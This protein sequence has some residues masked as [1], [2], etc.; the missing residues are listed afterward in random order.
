MCQGEL[1]NLKKKMIWER[2]VEAIT[3]Q[4]KGVTLIWLL[5]LLGLN[6]RK[7][8]SNVQHEGFKVDTGENF[9]ALRDSVFSHQDSLFNQMLACS[10][11]VVSLIMREISPL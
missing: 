4:D 3:C 7:R 10:S 11:E 6:K 1:L 2:G 9:L 8:G 5:L